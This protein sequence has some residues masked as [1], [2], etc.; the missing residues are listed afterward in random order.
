ME[1]FI[2]GQP[3]KTYSMKKII[4]SFLIYAGNELS[5][6]KDAFYLSFVV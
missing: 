2:L 3:I 4:K 1:F 6:I 5:F